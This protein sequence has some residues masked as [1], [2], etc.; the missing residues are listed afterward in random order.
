MIV[1]FPGH[2]RLLFEHSSGF[3]KF[4][5]LLCISGL[6]SGVMAA[7]I[8]TGNVSGAAVGTSFT[9]GIITQCILV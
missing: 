8:L 7:M 5:Y 2:T 3:V 1:V 9:V 4:D 6:N